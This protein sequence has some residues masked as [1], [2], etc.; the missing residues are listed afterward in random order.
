MVLS[1]YFYLIIII[2]LYIFMREACCKMIIGSETEY[3]DQISNS[4][5]RFLHITSR[6]CLWGKALIYFFSPSYA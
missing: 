2:G 5:Q 3:S 1:N 6:S 4:G